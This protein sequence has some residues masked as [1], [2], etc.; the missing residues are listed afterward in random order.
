MER[1]IQKVI[2]LILIFFL[3]W[4]GGCG[5]DRKIEKGEEINKG[6]VVNKVNVNEVENESVDNLINGQISGLIQRLQKRL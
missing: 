1:K 2:L 6:E 5:E 4:L 3:L